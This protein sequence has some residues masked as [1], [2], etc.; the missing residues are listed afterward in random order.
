ML[1]NEIHLYINEFVGSVTSKLIDQY[2]KTNVPSTVNW[3]EYEQQLIGYREYREWCY[4]MRVKPK[5]L[6]HTPMREI[7]KFT[8][9]TFS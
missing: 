8:Y 5:P 7:C 1:P 9:R 6:C 2:W 4:N 3:N